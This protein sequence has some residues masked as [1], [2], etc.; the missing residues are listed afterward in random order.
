MYNTLYANTN[1][2]N[3]VYYKTVNELNS[4]QKELKLVSAYLEKEKNENQLNKQKLEEEKNKKEQLENI[5]KNLEK[6]NIF[7]N[8][9]K[10]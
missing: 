5:K 3:N 4:T 9:R 8:R 1:E 7:F 10:K 2:D 6:K